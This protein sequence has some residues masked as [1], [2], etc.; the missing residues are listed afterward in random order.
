MPSN[1][2]KFLKFW[3]ISREV[4]LELNLQNRQA[5]EFIPQ[6]SPKARL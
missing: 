4:K 2:I 5:A 3:R 1:L 6:T